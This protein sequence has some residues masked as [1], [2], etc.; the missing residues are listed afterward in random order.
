MASV[1]MVKQ[2]QT[3][4]RKT[5]VLWHNPILKDYSDETVALGCQISRM[6]MYLG[7]ISISMAYLKHQWKEG[8][9]YH[10]NKWM[11]FLGDYLQHQ[12]T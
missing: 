2:D 4:T 8:N 11:N 5:Y 12:G 6:Q 1:L 10:Q 9:Q 3:R 7:H